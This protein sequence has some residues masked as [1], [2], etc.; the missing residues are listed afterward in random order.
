MCNDL[1]RVYGVE[2]PKKLFPEL[3]NKNS[4]VKAQMAKWLFSA[5]FLLDHCCMPL[6]S[7]AKCQ[8][9]KLQEDSSQEDLKRGGQN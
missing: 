5:I 9:E 7:S 6:M 2:D 8:I 1:C 4:I 3:L